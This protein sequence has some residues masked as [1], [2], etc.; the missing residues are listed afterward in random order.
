MGNGS[1]FRFDDGLG[2]LFWD[3]SYN[4]LQS[5]VRKC[6]DLLRYIAKRIESDKCFVTK[7]TT[8]CLHIPWKSV[9]PAKIGTLLLAVSRLRHDVTFC[10]DRLTQR[11]PEINHM[12]TWVCLVEYWTWQL[13][14]TAKRAEPLMEDIA[15]Q[16]DVM[17]IVYNY[18]HR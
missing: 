4:D 1:Y 9:N 8:I 7:P 15:F 18:L 6:V 12:I 13:M 2:G 10:W 16:K 3:I 11:H 5:S 14:H 17:S